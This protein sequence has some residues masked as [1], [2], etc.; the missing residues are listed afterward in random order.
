[1]ISRAPFQAGIHMLG[2]FQATP[3]TGAATK[4]GALRVRSEIRC[5]ALGLW[6]SCTSRAEIIRI[7]CLIMCLAR[8][9]EGIEHR[10]WIRFPGKKKRRCHADKS[11]GGGIVPEP[12]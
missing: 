6:P 2:K 5:D 7:F 12:G 3:G 10:E 8:G 11:G 9:E 4:E 1:M